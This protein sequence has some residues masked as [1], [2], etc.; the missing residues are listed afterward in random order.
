MPAGAS[1]TAPD[2]FVETS[3]PAVVRLERTGSCR[4][5]GFLLKVGSINRVGRPNALSNEAVASTD[6]VLRWGSRKLCRVRSSAVIASN[7][8][9]GGATVEAVA[10]LGKVVVGNGILVPTVCSRN[11]SETSVLCEGLYEELA[12]DSSQMTDVGVSG[13][14]SFE[15]DHRRIAGVV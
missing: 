9:G 11:T 2:Q 4:R 14:L 7:S 6:K 15:A 5:C 12:P 13:P 10:P 8:T 1:T 3:L